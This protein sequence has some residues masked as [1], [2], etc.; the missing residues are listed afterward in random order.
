MLQILAIFLLSV[1][2][3]LFFRIDTPGV[4]RRV[5][6][7]FLGHPDLIVGFNTFLPPGYKI[8]VSNNETINVHQPGQQML[9]FSTAPP[10]VSPPQIRSFPPRVWK[11]FFLCFQNKTKIIFGCIQKV[12]CYMA[13]LASGSK[14]APESSG[15]NNKRSSAWRISTSSRKPAF[16]PATSVR[17]ATIRSTTWS[18]GWVQSRH[19]LRQQD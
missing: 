1:V 4:I 10:D 17:S 13:F 8:E 3:L 7:L 5:S 2:S 12:A 9:S 19:Q 11:T 14:P 18:T 15:A 6:N 16:A